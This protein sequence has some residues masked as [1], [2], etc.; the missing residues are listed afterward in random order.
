MGL[1]SP[2]P[3]NL[4][5]HDVGLVI[6]NFET[7]FTEALPFPSVPRKLSQSAWV[8]LWRKKNGIS[9]KSFFMFISI[10]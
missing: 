4:A 8:W 10:G 9:E 3:G 2:R 5:F 6:D 1:D 7:E